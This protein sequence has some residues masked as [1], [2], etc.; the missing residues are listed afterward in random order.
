MPPNPVA[1]LSSK[2]LAD[3]DRRA[4]RVFE[5]VIYDTPP[6]SVA[7]DA[8]LISARAEG[9]VLVLDARKTRR[10]SAVKAVDQ[11]QRAKTTVLGVVINRVPGTGDAS[12]RYYGPGKANGRTEMPEVEP[13]R[14]A[15]EPLPAP[16]PIEYQPGA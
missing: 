15:I 14:D 10:P 8:S 16:P 6:L 12:Y 13:A 1:L 5:L 3:F 2:A 4:K 9:V 11:L 7:A